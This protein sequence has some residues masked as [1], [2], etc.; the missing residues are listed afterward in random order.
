M[1]CYHPEK[2]VG[3]D[4]VAAGRLSENGPSGLIASSASHAKAAIESEPV[5]NE[6]FALYT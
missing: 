3:G 6:Y 4:R 1:A 2:R 5:P